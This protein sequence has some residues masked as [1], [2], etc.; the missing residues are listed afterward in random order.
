M[1][2]IPVD[3][4]YEF[5]NAVTNYKSRTD[6]PLDN[7]EIDDVFNLRLVCR[8]FYQTAW[9]V[10]AKA[11]SSKVFRPTTGDLAKLKMASQ[12]PILAR[13]ITT[14]TFSTI[15]PRRSILDAIC[16]VIRHAPPDY[17]AI[18]P[19]HEIERIEEEYE[20]VYKILIKSY[21]AEF[22]ILLPAALSSFK[23]LRTINIKNERVEF[24][25]TFVD[26]P[27]PY[28]QHGLQGAIWNIFTGLIDRSYPTEAYL[29]RALLSDHV[30]PALSNIESLHL[31]E[32]GYYLQPFHRSFGNPTPASLQNL[33]KL[34]I[35]I[36]TMRRNEFGPL[37][38]RVSDPKSIARFIGQLRGLKVLKMTFSDNSW[39]L[40]ALQD[41][42]DFVRLPLLEE[43]SLKFVVYVQHLTELCGFLQNHARTLRRLSIGFDKVTIPVWPLL[44]HRIS[45]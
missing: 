28:I 40:E 41:M 14:L 6:V 9:T 16:Y 35:T 24:L 19:I 23:R 43:L 18:L 20:V 11:V 15:V 36:D 3:I 37:R 7:N 26:F 13:T 33:R 22:K 2:N 25:S 12:V 39:P 32:I 1:E 30:L 27:T 29:I 34:D 44:R 38:G 42:Q 21:W 45:Q 31:P 10:F 8:G 5:F 4:L 17:D